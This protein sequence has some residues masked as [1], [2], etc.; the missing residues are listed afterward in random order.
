MGRKSRSGNV[1]KQRRHA[2]SHEGL[3]A[4]KDRRVR[5][6]SHGRFKSVAELETHRARVS[7]K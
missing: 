1:A 4:R 6:S 2:R 7:R 3:A 5:R